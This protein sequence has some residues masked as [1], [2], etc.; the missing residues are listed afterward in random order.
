MNA[1]A[2]MDAERARIAAE[3]GA[4][5]AAYP[6]TNALLDEVMAE[7]HAED[8]VPGCPACAVTALTDTDRA[9]LAANGWVQP[10]HVG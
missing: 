7:L 2:Y 10:R 8:P 4:H 5:E 9:H 3:L 1:K 6:E